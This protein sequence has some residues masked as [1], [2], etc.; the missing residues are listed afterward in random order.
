MSA[1]ARQ[2]V[3][4]DRVFH[5]LAD[6]SRMA[7][8]ERLSRGATSV[9]ELAEPLAM[10]LPSVMKHLKVLEDGGL[11]RSSKTGRVRT[12]RIEPHA[13]T[14]IDKWV[15]QRRSAWNRG[16]DRL[17]QLLAEPDDQPSPGNKP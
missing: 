4:L 10:A 6:P 17:A 14:S 7:M 8:V 15:A 2:P 16:F 5:A 9:K 1:A 13:L 11:V 3:S 12:Y